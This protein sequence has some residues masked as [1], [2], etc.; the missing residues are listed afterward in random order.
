MCKYCEPKNDGSWR[1]QAR[2]GR[3]WR[4]FLHDKQKWL[5]TTTL[6]HQRVYVPINYCPHC[7]RMVK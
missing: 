7:G 2:Y 5:I 3:D 1:G 4:L 6:D